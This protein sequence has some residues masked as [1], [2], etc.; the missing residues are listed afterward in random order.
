MVT[1]MDRK[2]LLAIT[3]TLAFTTS[4]LPASSQAIAESVL[5]GAG[6]STATVKAGSALNSALNQSSKQLTGGIR[7]QL[8]QPPQTSTQQS[9]KNLLPKSQTEGTAI[10][11]TPQSGALIVSIQGAK[12]NCPLTKEKTS[13]REGNAVEPPLTNCISQN[14]SVK[15][16]SQKYK[17]VVTLSFPK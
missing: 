14:T 9:G 16:E 11:S 7:Q 3:L 2:V 6:S 5:L 8:S 15:P 13:T 12:P 4:S 17:S 1:R 10:P